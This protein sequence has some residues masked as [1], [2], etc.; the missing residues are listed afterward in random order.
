MKKK[1][2]PARSA[3]FWIVSV[4][5]TAAAAQAQLKSSD[6][7]QAHYTNVMQRS[8]WWR[9]ARF[10]M[11]IHFGAYAVP[12]RGEWVKS[13]ERLTT[14]QYQAFVD[15]FSPDDF[16]A[17]AWAKTAKAAGMKYAV[18]TAKH[19]DG[20]ALFDSKLSD[21]TLSKNWGGRDLVREFLDAFR[22]EGLRV[23]LYYSVID[24]H[25]PDYPN[26]GNHPQR[27]DSAYAKTK[28]NWDNYI[29][30]MHGQVEELVSRYGRIDIMWFDYSFDDYAGEKW[31]ANAL[32]Q[33]VRKHQPHII[34]N[35]RL[36][37]HAGT[38]SNKRPFSQ[39]GDFATP[40]QGVP[41]APILNEQGQP[42]PWET[43]LTLNNVW[44]FS[45]FDNNW[46]S[47]EL[48]V[49]T[50]VNCVSKNG[51]L[52]LNVGPDA[53]GNIPAESV[54]ILSAVGQWMQKN[55]TSIYGCGAASLAKPDWGRYTQ[56]GQRLFAHWMYPNIGMLNA[57]GLD[58]QQVKGAY[59]LANGARLPFMSTWWGNEEPGN[60]FIQVGQHPN[61][62]FAYSTVVDLHLK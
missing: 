24:W 19:H 34:L 6:A 22:A 15:A 51:N 43:C 25:H 39:L 9:E 11:F 1:Y 3:F 16:D 21:Y 46:K 60:C 50:L 59:L 23:G 36:E 55:S 7:L 10:G 41:D 20:Y 29:T 30:Y 8:A 61:K 45:A 56:K 4:L 44:G 58:A 13:N 57:K 12:G 17:K 53:R 33:M 26:V 54:D 32:V 40:E 48:I 31:K 35:N 52:L 62:P 5:A 37:K 49:Q 18:L 28:F 27:G 47:P 14:D 38:S 42:I 2:R